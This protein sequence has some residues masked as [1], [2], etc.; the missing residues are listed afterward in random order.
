M[1]NDD[2]V[3]YNQKKQNNLAATSTE[4]NKDKLITS[5]GVSVLEG[6]H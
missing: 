6:G 1:N 2:S 5:H 3:K 4:K